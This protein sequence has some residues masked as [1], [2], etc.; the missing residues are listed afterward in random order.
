MHEFS[1]CH[2]LVEK[3]LEETARLEP[4]VIR[5]NKIGVACG[6]LRQ[7]VPEYLQTAYTALT[8]GTIAEQSVLEIREI[9]I[10]GRCAA[11]GWEGE[12]AADYDFTCPACAAPILDILSGQEVYLETIEVEQDDHTAD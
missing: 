5:V 10:I 9:P 11:C 7:I 2:H 4:P 3:V 12:L 1:I 6:R 8:K